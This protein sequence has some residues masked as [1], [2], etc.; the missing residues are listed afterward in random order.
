MLKLDNRLVNF[1]KT[2]EGEQQRSVAIEKACDAASKLKTLIEERS[3]IVQKLKLLELYDIRT[4]HTYEAKARYL[5][6]KKF[7][8][9]ARIAPNSDDLKSPVNMRKFLK[10]VQ[11]QDSPPQSAEHEDSFSEEAAALRVLEATVLEGTH[12]SNGDE[13]FRTL[14]PQIHNNID[15][16]LSGN[17]LSPV[18][19]NQKEPFKFTLN[20]AYSPSDN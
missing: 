19:S 9:S 4:N 15:L 7:N 1:L 10:K 5:I 11:I 17:H 18:K 8:H 2:F 14:S 13:S 16:L 20:L 12:N 6:Q 3:A